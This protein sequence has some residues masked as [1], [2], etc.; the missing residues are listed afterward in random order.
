MPTFQEFINESAN[1]KAF[2]PETVGELK[3][4]LDRLLAEGKITK[5]TFIRPIGVDSDIY[6]PSHMNVRVES[7]LGDKYLIINIP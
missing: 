1:S 2:Y 6:S 7:V 3:I 5:S 4:L